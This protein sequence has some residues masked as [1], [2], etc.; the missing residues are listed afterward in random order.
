MKQWAHSITVVTTNMDL[1][2]SCPC[3]NVSLR[4][5]RVFGSL[6]EE[7]RQLLSVAPVSGTW[8]AAELS[9]PKFE[10]PGLVA[11]GRVAGSWPVTDGNANGSS[12]ASTV[13]LVT[14]LNCSCECFLWRQ[15]SSKILQS[16]KLKVQRH[17][18]TIFSESRHVCVRVSPGHEDT[19]CV[20]AF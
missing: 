2:F 8:I 10:F 13:S 3:L 16:A 7:E 9:E 18:P 17:R 1:C 15:E 20:A 5:H 14:C 12:A 4:L 6:L 19:K 11:F